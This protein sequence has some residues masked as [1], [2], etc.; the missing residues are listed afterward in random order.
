VREALAAAAPDGIDLFFDNVG[1]WQMVAALHN[2]KIHGRV[3]MC[4]AVSNFG[5]SDQPSLAELIEVVLRRVT[6]RGFIVRDFEALRAEFEERVSGWLA[7]GALV[8]RATVFEGIENAGAG[9]EG[10][11]NGANLG[12]ALIRLSD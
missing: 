8:D 11:L 7:S 2:M 12:K 4:G 1:G 3:S 10:L 9:L 5:T 6:I